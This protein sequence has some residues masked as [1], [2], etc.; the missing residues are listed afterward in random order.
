MLS[1]RI[2]VLLAI[3]IS[4]SR[5]AMAQNVGMS[6]TGATPDASAMLDIVSS[7]KGLLIPRV[8]L[9]ATDDEGPITSPATSLLV[10]NTPLVL[11]QPTLFPD[12]IIGMVQT[13]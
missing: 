6:S 13:G 11:Y 5:T 9:T 1:I 2:L 7:S 8:A 10:Y 4:I 3:T 12:I